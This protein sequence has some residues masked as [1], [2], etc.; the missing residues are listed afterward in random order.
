MDNYDSLACAIILQAIKDYFNNPSKQKQILKDLRSP[1]MDF[2][3]QGKSLLAAEQLERHPKEIQ[4]RLK[5][6]ESKP[7]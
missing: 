1:H 7:A 3:T 4:A 5:R 6:S 2:I